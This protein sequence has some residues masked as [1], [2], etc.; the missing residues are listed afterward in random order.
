MI[1]I[2]QL[3]VKYGQE[4]VL[5]IDERIQFDA[6]QRIGIIGGNG[7]GKTTL[8]NAILGLIP[9]EGKITREVPPSEMAVHLQFNEFVDTMKC[10]YVM[11]AILNTSIK[12]NSE[13]RELIE[14]FDMEDHLNKKYKQLSGGQKQRF[15]LIMVLFQ[16]SPFTFFDEVT[17][18]LDFE[19]RQKLIK[20]IQDW[21]QGSSDSFCMVSHYY[22]ELEHLVDQ[23]VL[24][25]QGNL[26]A[27]GDKVE[28]F[29]QYCG[30]K[31]VQ[32]EQT[33]ENEKIAKPFR[34]ILA[35]DQ[36]IAISINS[37]DEEKLLLNQLMEYD[38]DY[39]R[40]SHD[41]ELMVINAKASFYRGGGQ[42]HAS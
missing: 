14:Y 32:F 3:K 26:I 39:R 1:T 6:G 41:I 36:T 13:L 20:K 18:G 10:K 42:K 5:R 2:E 23:I 28:L 7:A 27:Y 11:E 12:Q 24:L 17:S 22:E 25:D 40:T 33:P 19:T 8:I 35:P 29:Q 31:V 30:Q 15:T 4:T 38:I 16:K 34:K 9:Y 37:M 21:Y